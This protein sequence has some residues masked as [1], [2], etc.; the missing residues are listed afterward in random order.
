MLR[1]RL[2]KFVGPQL[3]DRDASSTNDRLTFVSGID[4]DEL[5][6]ER[7]GDALLISVMASSA[8]KSRIEGWFGQT[9]GQTSTRW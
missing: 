4:H 1:A 9:S 3:S 5:W 8:N 6:L 2:A 7:A